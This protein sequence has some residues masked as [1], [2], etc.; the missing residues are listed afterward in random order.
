MRHPR[1]HHSRKDDM[2]QHIYAH[3]HPESE[4]ESRRWLHALVHGALRLGEV[5]DRASRRSG[6]R[7]PRAR[8][9]STSTVTPFARTSRRG[10]G[11]RRR[12]ATP[13]SSV[14]AG[15]RPASRATAER[16]R[17]RDL[18]VRG[19]TGRRRALSSRS[20][21]RSSRCTCERRVDE[22][23]RRDVNGLYAKAFAGRSRASLAWTTRTRRPRLRRSS[24]TPSRLSPR[25]P[26]RSWSRR[27]RS[28]ASS[29]QRCE[30]ERSRRRIG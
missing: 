3:E 30:R 29:R 23:A 13:T 16:D 18:A 19:D 12:T 25:S 14:S 9:S 28:S 4:T 22:C 21:D 24:S 10:S 27:S 7:P 2:S 26:R 17:R 5:D 20:M 11:S 6:D 15:S 1:E 8:T